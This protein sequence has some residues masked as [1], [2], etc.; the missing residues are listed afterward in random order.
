MSTANGTLVI[1]SA[2]EVMELDSVLEVVDFQGQPL[3]DTIVFGM[4]CNQKI[5]VKADGQAKVCFW[6]DFLQELKDQGLYL[7]MCAECKRWT[8]A[9][10]NQLPELKKDQNAYHIIDHN[11]IKEL[12]PMSFDQREAYVKEILAAQ[13]A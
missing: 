9:S 1:V 10:E 5:L 4:F 7:I 13:A 11:M 12:R 8:F 6:Q 3:P 2:K